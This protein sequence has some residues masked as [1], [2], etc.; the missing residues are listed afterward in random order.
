[1]KYILVSLLALSVGT[2]AVA[3]DL[4]TSAASPPQKYPPCSR[5]VTDECTQMP[6]AHHMAHKTMKH[7][8]HHRAH[9][10]HKSAQK[11]S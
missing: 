5:T 2:A 6:A 10:A 8:R 9:R 11:A 7:H 4:G 3:A 1:M